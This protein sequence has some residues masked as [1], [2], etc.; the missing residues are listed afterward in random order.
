MSTNVVKDWRNRGAID[1]VTLVMKK[2]E[3]LFSLVMALY[4][5][6]L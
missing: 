5:L 4:R 1:T 2:R 3:Q 6:S